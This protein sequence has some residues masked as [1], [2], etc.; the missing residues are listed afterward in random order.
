MIF[1]LFLAVLALMWAV[2][3][4][5]PRHYP[6]GRGQVE[7]WHDEAQVTCTAASARAEEAGE[8]TGQSDLTH[9]A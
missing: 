9:V 1:L 4:W 6:P 5:H 8:R 2:L 3:V 7:R